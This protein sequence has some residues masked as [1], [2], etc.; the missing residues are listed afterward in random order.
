M[1]EIV[2]IVEEFDK[3]GNPITLADKF[4]ENFPDLDMTLYYNR[5]K[6]AYIDNIGRR[7]KFQTYDSIVNF[8]P[9]IKYFYFLP[10]AR[11]SN[12]FH[13]FIHFLKRDKLARLVQ[14]DVSMLI[15]Y[16]Q[17][18][19][20]AFD[21]GFFVKSFEWLQTMIW[22]HLYHINPEYATTIKYHFLSASDLTPGFNNFLN[23]YFNGNFRFHYSPMVFSSVHS[24]Y[25][26]ENGL[27]R[28]KSENIL[29]EYLHSPKYK[30]FLN[31]NMQPRYNREM[32]IHG[33]RAFD[34]LSEGYVSRNKHKEP[35]YELLPM[36]QGAYADK[37]RSDMVK[38]LEIINLDVTGQG[39]NKKFA[40]EFFNNSCYDLISETGTLYENA[41]VVDVSILS[42]KTAKSLAFGRPFMINGGPHCLTLLKK[43]GFET[44]DFLFDESYNGKE[45]LIDRQEIIIKNIENYKGK[46]N[47]LWQKILY[48]KDVMIRNQ[49]KFF[50]FD[51]EEHLVKELTS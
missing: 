31:L 32:L 24:W 21:V 50:N 20:P 36:Y 1:H 6:Q 26:G 18:H 15:V 9:N 17:E 27:N 51:V 10:I 40:M 37:I 49:N 35:A 44:Y 7:I 41:E 28:K 30:Q 29:N 16:D 11:W 25:A 14:N 38:P 46:L 13:N 8:N 5:T 39:Y 34:L 12:D 4:Y 42:E 43:L 2:F 45:N 33:L 47:D 22:D 23:S 19:L 48:N 3:H